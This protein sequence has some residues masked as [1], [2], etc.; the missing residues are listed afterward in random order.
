MKRILLRLFRGVKP[1]AALVLPKAVL[2]TLGASTV[3]A[4]RGSGFFD[5]SF[6]HLQL[7][8]PFATV[9]EAIEHYLAEGEEAG[10]NPNP[11]FDVEW[12]KS[13]YLDAATERASPLLDF[14]AHAGLQPS[15]NPSA[16]FDG[17]WYLRQYPDVAAAGVNPLLHYMTNGQREGRA[18]SPLAGQAA[19]ALRTLSLSRAPLPQEGDT[20]LTVRLAVKPVPDAA[21]RTGAVVAAAD[22]RSDLP[23]GRAQLFPPRPYVAEFKNIGIVG[24][25]RL[26][27]SDE[28]T[29]L[30][31]EI[32]TFRDSKGWSVRPYLFTMH[33]D[34]SVAFDVHRRYPSQIARGAHLMHEYANNYYHMITE[35]LPRLVA[36][37]EGGLDP[38][39]PLLIQ[40][41][42]HPNLLVLLGAVN[43]RK[44]DLIT[45]RNQQVYTVAE[46]H[47]IS[48]VASVQDI[49]DR[50]RQPEETV[51]HRSLTRQVAD[52]V[53]AR[54]APGAPPQRT[55]KLY[56]RRGSR[57]R[58]LLNEQAVEEMLVQ[59]GF[60]IVLLDGLSVAAQVHLFRQA[61][62]VVAPT[63]AAV[64][65]ILWCQPDTLI[66]VLS[67]DHVG[68]APEIWGQV[69]EVAGCLVNSLLCERAYDRDD[70]L[71]IHDNY[72]VDLDALGTTIRQLQS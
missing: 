53:I 22:E 3:L 39:L 72:T 40:E 52:Q 59:Q 35:V 48:D 50:A 66:L 57:Y 11:F 32:A 64:T 44:R 2:E 65:N 17:D 23:P 8:T 20:R 43:P 68:A 7:P 30:S 38:S 36:A 4:V 29:V 9:D 28:A 60:E 58:G 31:D 1:L 37:E 25:T 13:T 19:V 67:A 21:R 15:R 56:I 33:P 5:L 34:G 62:I 49:Y 47:F 71:C 45:L 46:L 12:Y 54:F 26:L 10:L 51:L 70:E 63:G 69:G 41:G 16:G 55:R 61:R 27:V 14:I 24:G 42:L 18:P 6:Y